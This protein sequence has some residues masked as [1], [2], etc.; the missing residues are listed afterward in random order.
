[1][2]FGV[3]GVC[4]APGWSKMDLHMGDGH[5]MDLHIGDSLLSGCLTSVG[6]LL[7]ILP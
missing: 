4:S 7:G 2:R 6:C 1:M 3:H 5:V